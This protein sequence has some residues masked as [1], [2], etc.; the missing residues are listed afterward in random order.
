MIVINWLSTR[1][2]TRCTFEQTH[3]DCF[4]EKPIKSAIV[5]I[6]IRKSRL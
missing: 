6:C 3:R 1:L 2:E 4:Y 5:E